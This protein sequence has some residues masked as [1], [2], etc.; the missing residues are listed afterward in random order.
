MSRAQQ[1][2]RK[3]T[4]WVKGN[5]RAKR[6]RVMVGDEPLVSSSGASL[7]LDAARAAGLDRALSVALRRWRRPRAGHDPGKVV[8]DVALA[9]A[10]GGDCLASFNAILTC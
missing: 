8:L 2:K 9:I 5:G 4:A 7:M 3:G 1:S 10:L 6:V